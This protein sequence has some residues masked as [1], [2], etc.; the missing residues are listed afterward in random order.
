MPVTR[1]W[2]RMA[3]G[4]LTVY[5]SLILAVLL[6]LCLTLIEGARSNAI[7]VESELVSNIAVNSIM[8]EFNRE[9]MKQYN[10]FAIDTSYGT[11]SASINNTEAHLDKYLDKNFSTE[12]VFLSSF[13]YRDFMGITVDTAQLEG[14]LFMTDQNGAVFRRR[15]YEAIKDDIGLTLMS[16]VADW[17][18]VIESNEWNSM[19]VESELV[20]TQQQLLEAQNADNSADGNG[21]QLT[22]NS[23]GE[24][25]AEN[26][27]EGTG[28]NADSEEESG[29][30]EVMISGEM[31]DVSTLN[32]NPAFDA[33][34][35]S[36]SSY[37]LRNFM[38]D[39]SEI[40]ANRINSS[41]LVCSRRQDGMIN[42]GNL[43]LEEENGFEEAIER[44]VFQEYLIKYMGRY[45]KEADNDALKYQ[46]EYL[47]GGH[48]TDWDN[49]AA[50]CSLLFALRFAI[51]YSY[52]LTDEQKGEEADTV[53]E[54]FAILTFMEAYKDVY[55]HLILL[56]WSYNEARY[57]VGCL[58][59]GSKIELIKNESNWHVTM[60]QNFFDFN[61]D[62]D[63]DERGLTY[64]DYLRIF[65]S[66]ANIE[67]LSFRAMDMI[68]A[69]IHMTS[70]NE[71]FRID[72]CL[73]SIQ[74]KVRTIS[75]FG[76]SYEFV[77]KR[78]YE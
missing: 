12:D 77:I 35:R 5:L 71:Y 32:M 34:A 31:T 50:V 78:R 61:P 37:F 30:N 19:D 62:R 59:A 20:S 66:L 22:D 33:I 1:N 49:L 39:T 52:I 11:N 57:D 16:E 48:D 65:L 43:S 25:G 54:V 73:D 68:E 3:K 64:V 60:L 36:S 75:R 21:N 44:F 10:L 51:D 4:Y 67:L 47:L 24:A 58:L 53:A 29:I 7:Q 72:A 2:G 46:V 23:D 26:V 6:S 69:D 74:A 9:L 38:D 13:L 42:E 41:S 14:A 70:G 63:G 45:Q 27:S 55:K 17:V 56:L 8:A 76:Y 18:N 28:E 40:S 15:A